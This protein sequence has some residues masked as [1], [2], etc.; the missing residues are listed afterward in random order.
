MTGPT[1]FGSSVRWDQNADVADRDAELSGL[2]SRCRRDHTAWINGDGSFYA[3]PDGGSIMGAVG[4]ASLGGDGTFQRQL[5]VARQWASGTGEIELINGSIDGDTA[6]LVMIERATVIFAGQ[7][8]PHRWDLRVTEIF[9]R[10]G[11]DWVRVHRHADPLVDRHDIP[12]LVP[13]L[14]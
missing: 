4:G 13:L 11:E 8:E 6:W 10:D 14:R 9:H 5:A 1:M 3:L 12:S 7:S 2:L